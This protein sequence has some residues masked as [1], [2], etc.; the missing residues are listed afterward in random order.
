MVNR[1][2]S[3]SALSGSLL[4]WRLCF[5]G[6]HTAEDFLERH[7]MA[8]EAPCGEE[9]AGT[10]PLAILVAGIIV[11]IIAA[12]FNGKLVEHYAVGLLGISV[13]FFNLPDQA[14]LHVPPSLM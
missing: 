1:A 2:A 7:G 10:V 5:S 4:V 13:R 12:E 6:K 11:V 9:M 3:L 8:A 14:G